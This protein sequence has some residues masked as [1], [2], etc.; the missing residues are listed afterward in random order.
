MAVKSINTSL[1]LT[2]GPIPVH[3][4]STQLNEECKYSLARPLFASST[5]FIAKMRSSILVLAFS[6]LAVALPREGE[7]EKLHGVK[8]PTVVG[9]N[10]VAVKQ[11]SG[12][13]GGGVGV[14]GIGGGGGSSCDGATCDLKV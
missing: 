7:D 3:S 10:D 13:T 4:A 9:P 14:V 8:G 1:F 6:A 2:R 12:G 5:I 11:I